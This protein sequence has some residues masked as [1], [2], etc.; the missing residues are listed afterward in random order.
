MANLTKAE[1]A[2][3]VLQHLGLLGAG[4]SASAEDDGLVQEAIDA[5]H[6]ELRK[7]GLVPFATS[8]IPE[9]AQAPLRDFVAAE[10]GPAFGM[11]TLPEKEAR[12]ATARR[13]LATQVAA[14]RH[15]IPI[16]AEYF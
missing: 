10:V 7:E 5:V 4:Q 15:P 9:W 8:A 14:M 1:L 16:V 11:V 3:R 13:R 2:A 6:A 12:Q